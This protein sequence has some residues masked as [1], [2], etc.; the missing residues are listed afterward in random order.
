MG[1]S[2]IA[3]LYSYEP[4]IASV[5]KLGATDLFLLIDH[6]PDDVQKKAITEVKSSLGKYIN[7]KL[8]K[9]D[10]YDIVSVSKESV[11]LIDKIAPKSRVFL[12]I[13]AARKTKALGLMFAGY[14]RASKID[15]IFYVTKENKSVV[16]LPKLGFNLNKSQ[17]KI[18]KH[19]NSMSHQG[20]TMKDVCHELNMSKSMFYKTLKELRDKGLVHNNE[21]TDAGRIS[22]L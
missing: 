6:N 21:I 2:I 9:T 7:I 18:L 17:Q 14:A 1:V 19:L 16:L 20:Q 22:L 12:N 13:S 8:V 4:V 11:K 3:T 5:T 15:K 10:L